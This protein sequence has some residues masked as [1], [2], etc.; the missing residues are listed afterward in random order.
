MAL[1]PAGKK[2][3]TWREGGRVGLT[4]RQLSK[5]EVLHGSSGDQG[6]L[7][8]V[9]HMGQCVHAD[10]EVC[11]VHSHC[12]LAHGRLVRV[13]RRL[14]VV[15]EGDNGGT[16]TLGR[17]GG[18]ARR[19]RL[20]EGGRGERKAHLESWLGGSHSVCRWSSSQRPFPGGP[21]ESWRS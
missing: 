18:V 19:G 17:R 7:G 6:L 16:H 15:R 5:A 20:N 21:Q 1:M 4:S 9:E 11:D 3:D 14:V 2:E 13:S 12:L 10:V 8:V